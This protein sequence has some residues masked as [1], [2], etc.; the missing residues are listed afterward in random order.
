MAAE[1]FP[2]IARLSTFNGQPGAGFQPQLRTP[3][4]FAKIAA[5]TAPT[6]VIAAQHDQS[7]PPELSRQIAERI[8]GAEVVVIPDAAHIA[9]V[10]QPAAVT[11]HMLGHVTS[12]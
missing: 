12:R 6:L 11:G 4:T 1:A 9:N 3:N 5:I 10:E 2:V 7:T 8:P